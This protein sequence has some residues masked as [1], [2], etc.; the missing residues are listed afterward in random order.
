MKINKA[1]KKENKNKIN[2]SEKAGAKHI[3]LGIGFKLNAGILG[4][5]GVFVVLLAVL[6][7]KSSQY[8]TQYTQVLDN[9][10]KITY[11]KMNAT[12]VSHT[13][14]NMCGVGGDIASGG[15]VEIVDNIEKY[16]QEIGENIPDS[17]EFTETR[18]QYDK[19]QNEV[20]KY[21]NYYHDV[22]A[23]CGDKYS[24]KGLA[25]AKSMDGNATFVNSSAD[26]LLTLEIK[27]SEQV[28]AII[29]A[30]FSRTNTI[31]VL[32][33]VVATVLV[34][35]A[36]IFLS[37][38]ITGSIKRLQNQLAIMSEGDLTQPMLKV[39]SKDEAGLA[40]IAF[41]KMKTNLV[42]LI[43]KVMGATGDIKNATAVVNLSID[44]NTQGSTR[45]SEAVEGMLAG[46][47][48][49]KVE[50][51]YT[52]DQIESMESISKEMDEYAHSIYHNS[53]KTL[54][55][56]KDGMHRIKAYVSQMEEVNKAM[57]EMESVFAAFGETTKGMSEALS[58][59]TSIASQTNLLSLNASIEA[60][61]AG[62]AGR[63]FAVVATEIRDLADNSQTAAA[64]IGQMIEVVQDQAD[65]MSRKLKE[66]MEQ[67][68]IG[69]QLTKETSESFVIIQE[70]TNEVSDNVGGIIERVEVLTRMIT[71]TIDGINVIKNAADE[72]VVEINEI[73]AIVAEESANLE[74]VS[75]AMN[76]LLGLTKELDDLVSEF[77]L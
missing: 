77:K 34:L 27:R 53:D 13:V 37:K 47:E 10:S 76:K 44:E 56:A 7:M 50:V 20:G 61:R 33:A 59:I 18:T 51:K 71:E 43:S 60:A 14:V 40:T 73:S 63:G 75:D 3:G 68:E 17:T 2:M 11:I 15:H 28:E 67:L 46:L 62:E 19:F 30:D 35:T 16:V 4:T 32:V 52:V 22:L 57:H 26:I 48:Q 54:A 41:N 29:D 42:N 74:E 58:S 72:N 65:N 1:I 6:I 36:M 23:Q 49:Q 45:I 69:N 38:R 66:S 21:I 31:I 9:I 12:K 8:S 25:A 5:V 70:G 55:N 39:T 64:K 24:T